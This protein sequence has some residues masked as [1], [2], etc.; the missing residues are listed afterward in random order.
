MRLFRRR[1]GLSPHDTLIDGPQLTAL[2]QQTPNGGVS[3]VGTPTANGGAGASD[4]DNGG[5]PE[6][7]PQD[8]VSLGGTL[9]Y[10]ALSMAGSHVSGGGVGVGLG[11]AGSLVGVANAMGTPK[12]A[13]K[14]GEFL[15]NTD[16]GKVA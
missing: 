13:K 1:S 10:D 7:T 12:S 3:A 2:R 6:I 9:D 5:E 8:A 11:V 4:G 14:G 16:Y 15:S